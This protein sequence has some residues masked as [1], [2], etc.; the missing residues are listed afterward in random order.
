MNW[1]EGKLFI[2][3]NE[4][5][6]VWLFAQQSEQAGFELVYIGAA[7]PDAIVRKDDRELRVEFEYRLSNFLTHGHDVREC[8]LVI[9]WERDVNDFPLPV[10]ELSDPEWKETELFEADT[11]DLEIYHWRTKSQH[12]ERS[13]ARK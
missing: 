2:P 3:V 9:V 10:I 1:I 6:V 11:K 12:L 4:F 5:G 8:D 7:F 13:L